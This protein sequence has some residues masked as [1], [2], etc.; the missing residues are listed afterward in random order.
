MI[1]RREDPVGLPAHVCVMLNIKQSW[2][3]SA[4]EL[5]DAFSTEVF[6]DY[7]RAKCKS[8]GNTAPDAHFVSNL[9]YINHILCP[10]LEFVEV[11]WFHTKPNFGAW[12]ILW[13]VGSR[14]P[15]FI[16][17][18]SLSLELKKSEDDNKYIFL[19]RK[20][21]LLLFWMIFGFAWIIEKLSEIRWLKKKKII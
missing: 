14:L 16:K 9:S 11:C 12:L 20:V 13:V 15:K 4:A 19:S 1:C 2:W 3:S 7:W 8:D 6:L 18:V 21:A 10:L 17:S 5:V